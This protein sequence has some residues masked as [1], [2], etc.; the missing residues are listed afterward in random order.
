M[1]GALLEIE[2]LAFPTVGKT[3]A[4]LLLRQAFRFPSIEAS[5][6]A[7]LASRVPERVPWR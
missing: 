3:A 6:F 2:N 5:A 1:S 4:N 7:S